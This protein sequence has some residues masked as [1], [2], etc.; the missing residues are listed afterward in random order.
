M[1]WTG[2]MDTIQQLPSYSLSD[3]ITKDDAIAFCKKNGWRYE[4]HESAPSAGMDLVHARPARFKT[5]G[6]NFSVKRGGLPVGGLPS[7]QAMPDKP[8]GNEPRKSG[9]GSQQGSK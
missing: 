2:T 1:G 4:V 8:L 3:F 5:Y 7:E 9:R 6:D